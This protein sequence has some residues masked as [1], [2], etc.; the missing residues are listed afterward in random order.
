MIIHSRHAAEEE[1]NEPLTLRVRNS[2]SRSRSLQQTDSLAG[3]SPVS[4]TRTNT[5]SEPSNPAVPPAGDNILRLKRRR[6]PSPE[7]PQVAKSRRSSHPNDDLIL[8]E[9]S[10]SSRSTRHS[11]SHAVPPV[12]SS[13]RSGRARSRVNY[14]EPKEEDGEEEEDEEE[15]GN[16]AGG[17]DDDDDANDDNEDE[18]S[19][20]ARPNTRN[21]GSS[22]MHEKSVSKLRSSRRSRGK[23]QDRKRSTRTAGSSRKEKSRQHSDDDEDSDQSTRHGRHSRSKGKKLKVRSESSEGS[24]EEEVEDEEEDVEEEEEVVEQTT[25]SKRVVKAPA[26]FAN[27]MAAAMENEYEKLQEQRSARRRSDSE[28]APLSSQPVRQTPSQRFQQLEQQ[29]QATEREKARNQAQAAAMRSARRVDPE[30]KRLM[31][32]VVAHAEELDSDY[33]VFADPVTEEIAPGYFELIEHPVDLSTIR[34]VVLS[35]FCANFIY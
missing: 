13:S 29:R 6:D 25:R 24:D 28:S 8:P 30:V 33:N 20:E 5:R 14:S 23:E 26:N 4:R 21:S 18:D 22:R 35:Q 10:A 9:K 3:L 31:L 34:Y 32:Q 1:E 17:N 12:N 7:P 27:D 11:G 2:G 19:E 16:E 15:E